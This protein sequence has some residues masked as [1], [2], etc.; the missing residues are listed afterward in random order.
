MYYNKPDKVKYV[1]MCRYIDDNIYS[2]SYDEELVYEYLYHL[3][4]MVAGKCNYFTSKSMLDEFGIYSATYYYMRLTDKRQFESDEKIEP[5]RSIL[6]YLRSTIY[7]VKNE[8]CKK[9]DVTDKLN[10]FVCVDLDSMRDY[11]DTHYDYVGVVDF[12]TCLNNVYDVI[13]SVV[14]ESPYR[15]NIIMRDNIYISCMLSFLNSITITNKDKNRLNNFKLSTTLTPRLLESI[16]VS[17]RYDTTILYHLPDTMRSYVA[18][19]TNKSRVKMSKCLSSISH[20]NIQTCINM[21][22]LL[23]SSSEVEQ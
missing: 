14:D 8:F 22:N 15:D 10:D 3:S 23:L 2:E 11:A 12:K 6:N 5:I 1:D 17:E 19:L 16:Y 21:K 13:K 4:I 18:V 7:S 9:F 20:S